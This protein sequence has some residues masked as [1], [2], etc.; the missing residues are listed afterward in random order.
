MV[1]LVWYIP[2]F[3]Y[4]TVATYTYDAWGNVLTATGDM[5]EINPLRYRGYYYDSETGFYYL[6]SRYYDPTICRFINADGYA[7]TGQG[8]I[9]CNMFAYCNNNPAMFL[10]SSGEMLQYNQKYHACTLNDHVN[11]AGGGVLIG[12]GLGITGHLLDSIGNAVQNAVD[13]IGQAIDRARQAWIESAKER[14]TAR[15]R[16]ALAFAII[17]EKSLQPEVHHIVAQ[18]AKRAAPAREI[19][20]KL[21]PG[22][23]TNIPEN[24]IPLKAVVHRRLHTTTYYTM[25]NK[26]IKEAYDAGKGNPEQ[27]KANVLAALA[28]LSAFLETLNA[29][30]PS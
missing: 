22:V 17:N 30:A 21:F 16:L 24:K 23:G 29:L 14:I 6:Q 27:Q 28:G 20:N 8:V 25:V 11:G 26:V 4:K 10:D 3:E 18:N 5:A 2:G 13:G 15:M 7:S 19:L 9:G 12:V 1:K